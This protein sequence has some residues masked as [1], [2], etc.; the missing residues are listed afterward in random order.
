MAKVVNS[1][2]S[3]AARMLD[4]VPYLHTH[5][6]I[7]LRALA[8]NFGVSESEMSADLTNLWMCGLPGYTPL[9]LIDLSF[10][11][12]Y[13]TI[14]NA[15]TLAHPRS[16]NKEEV[17]ALLLGLDLVKSALSNEREDLINNIDSL[18]RRLRELIDLQGFLSA[19]PESDGSI[20]A[21]IS[22]AINNGHAVEIEYHS[23]YAD[24]VTQRVILPM[25]WDQDEFHEYVFA[26]C[27]SA[28]SFRTFRLDRITH[29]S[30]VDRELLPHNIEAVDKVPDDYVIRIHHHLRAA[31]ELF[32]LSGEDKDLYPGIEKKISSF[33]QEWISRMIFSAATS[34]EL[35][36]PKNA[37]LDIVA[38]AKSVL[39][40]YGL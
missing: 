31:R 13:V 25:K 30:R 36:S 18:S 2:L 1:P 10:E 38:S 33:T 32:E 4:L 26:Y 23:L 7:E 28:K 21:I 17:V 9:E 12:G 15:D 16:L 22:S 8:Q 3:R 19:K 6:G 37:R 34:V 27:D 40:L 14:T 5:Q 20:R 11:S 39:A 24:R 35:I 29:C